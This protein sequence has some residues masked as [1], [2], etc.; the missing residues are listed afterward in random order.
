VVQWLVEISISHSLPSSADMKNAWS[1]A[2]ISC[3][4]LYGVVVRRIDQSIVS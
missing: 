1:F 2:S 4:S 3:Q